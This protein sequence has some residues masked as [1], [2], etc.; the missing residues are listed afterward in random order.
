MSRPLKFK[1][2]SD[3]RLVKQ[4]MGADAA[5]RPPPGVSLAMPETPPPRSRGWLQ[6]AA[7]AYGPDAG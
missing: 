6:G 7:P 2:A 4:M 5:G 3:W 1:S